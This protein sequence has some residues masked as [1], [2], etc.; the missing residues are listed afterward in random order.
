M[1]QV[2]E[3][4]VDISGLTILTVDENQVILVHCFFPANVAFQE[5][6]SS[7]DRISFSVHLSGLVR[8]LQSTSQKTDLVSFQLNDENGPVDVRIVT[9]GKQVDFT[10]HQTIIVQPLRFAELSTQLYASVC[11]SQQENMIAKL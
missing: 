9:P 8:A 4:L 7:Q 2:V 5:F 3:F 6:E 1:L 11:K 10:I